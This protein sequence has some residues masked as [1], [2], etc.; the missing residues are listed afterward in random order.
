MSLPPEFQAQYDAASD[1]WLRRRVLWYCGFMVVFWAIMGAIRT[2]KVA[3]GSLLSDPAVIASFLTA[4]F[5]PIAYLAAAI[6]IFRRPAQSPAL[7]RGRL[8]RLVSLII[9]ISGALSELTAPF[10]L[11]KI[12]TLPV[13]GM[14]PE[15]AARFGARIR[16]VS[17]LILNLMVVFIGHFSASLF[18][19]WTV[20]EAAR[21]L[22]WLLGI[23]AIAAAIESPAPL[24]I[25][26]IF[27]VLLP[28]AGA[29]GI[30]LS[31][32]RYARFRRRFG[33]EKVTERYGEMNR[34]LTDARRIHEALFPPPITRG[35]VHLAYRYE[36]MRQIGG[37][38]LYASPVFP[39]P[40]AAPQ[41]AALSVVLIDVTG[42]GV[43]AALTVHSVHG[44]LD[45]MF[46]EHPG[47]KPGEVLTALNRYAGL[48]L[49]RHSV[50]PSALCL[51]VEP[52]ADLLY[53]ASAGHPPAFLRRA[54]GRIETL[55]P[56]TFLLGA[57]DAPDFAPDE[58]SIAFGPGDAVV[59]YTDGATEALDARGQMLRPDGVRAA[60]AGYVRGGAP[61]RP[62]AGSSPEPEGAL[63]AA[64]LAAVTRHRHGLPTDD[65][66]IV[67]LR[68]PFADVT[69]NGT[70]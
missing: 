36:P 13:T 1:A 47:R 40:A 63:A 25:R 43:P 15:T 18:I 19:P 22:L 49:A 61:S 67:E 20:R 16:A 62:S 42:H 52:A 64:V 17:P 46:I 26:L 21:P 14:D 5:R 51:R 34:E 35:P 70:N 2:L 59:A 12:H 33:Q 56:T 3:E 7:T 41:G 66:L 30:A 50:Y 39:A 57:C 24:F 9:F 31:A 65:A 10:L 4:V 32:W 60:I 29:P 45:R 69:P 48:L 6:Y 11:S 68:R 55:D 53:W 54:D 44:E 23:S 28:L 38:F 27:V 37:D 8:I 58:R